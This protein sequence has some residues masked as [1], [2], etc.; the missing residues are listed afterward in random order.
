MAVRQCILR[1]PLT[2]FTSEKVYTTRKI[3][4][5]LK[6]LLRL[7]A[8][9]QC[10]CVVEIASEPMHLQFSSLMDS[11]EMVRACR[12]C[13]VIIKWNATKTKYEHKQMGFWIVASISADIT[14]SLL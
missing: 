12:A 11:M 3:I 4:I 2:L 14:L 5:T 10:G 1:V 9:I 8:L 13:T 7:L 6:V